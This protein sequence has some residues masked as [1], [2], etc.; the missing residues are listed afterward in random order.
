MRPMLEALLGKY[1][2]QFV[3]IILEV[4][5]FALYMLVLCHGKRRRGRFYQR[6]ILLWAAQLLLCLPISVLRTGQDGL[7]ARVLLELFLSAEQLAAVFFLYEEDLSETLLMFSAILVTKNM[8]GNTVQFLLNLAG[9]ND[10]ETISFFPELVPARDWP[11]YIALHLALLFLTAY[12]FRRGERNRH[13]HL[14]LSAAC[15]FTGTTLVLRCLIQPTVRLLQPDDLP[16]IF[17][18]IR[19]LLV[20]IYVLLAAIRAGLLSRKTAETELD[21]TRSLLRQERKRYSEMRDTIEVINM[22]CHDLKHQLSRVQGKL[23]EE[24]TQALRDAIELYDGNIRT[25]SEIVDTVLYG[26]K[27][28]C[29]KNGIRLS[30]MCDGTAVRFMEPSQLY[31]LLDNALENAVEA[32]VGLEADDRV[33]LVTIGSSGDNAVLEVSNY[34]DPAALT[35]EEETSKPDKM[36]HGYGLKSMRYIAGVYGGSVEVRTEGNMFFLTITIPKP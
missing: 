32:S 12:L 23:T 22:R 18:C 19:A 35:A 29:E 34:F 6:F 14:D 28:V 7:P 36:H 30:C 33:I 10:K 31:S 27:L 9:K 11:I 2:F 20:L 25:G 8:S 13:V 17:C 4:L 15:L 24:E 21:L 1:Y 26:K 16:P 5:R 3:I